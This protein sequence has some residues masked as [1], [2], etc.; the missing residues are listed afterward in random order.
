MLKAEKEKAD[1][2]IEMTRK[3][4]QDI[5]KIRERNDQKFIERTFFDQMRS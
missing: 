3:K 4:T 2:K 1:K 5:L